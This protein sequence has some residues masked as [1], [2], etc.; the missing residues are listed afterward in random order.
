V[1]VVDTKG[2]HAGYPKVVLAT[3]FQDSMDTRGTGS[4]LQK[5]LKYSPCSQEDGDKHAGG[6]GGAAPPGD[7]VVYFYKPQANCTA[8]VSLCGSSM[9]TELLVLSHIDE[10]GDP[11]AL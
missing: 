3:P 9:D 2:W 8:A 7:D 5:L 1:Q 11:H 4:E 6:V 10:V